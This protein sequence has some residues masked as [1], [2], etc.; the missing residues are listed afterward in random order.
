MAAGMVVMRRI[1]DPGFLA[2]VTRK[3]EVMMD[4]LRRLQKE[5][6]IIGDVRGSIDPKG[7][8][9]LMDVP[10]PSELIATL[11]QRG[12]FENGLIMERGGRNG[13]VMRCLCA[14]NISDEDMDRAMTIFE[15]VVREIDE[16]YR[17]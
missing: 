1:S 14:L 12:C 15:K 13:S 8:R 7:P 9:D 6:S 4:R 17:D 3:G 5:V 2:E 16:G 10:E 11:V